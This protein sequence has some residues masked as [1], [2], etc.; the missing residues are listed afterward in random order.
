MCVANY[1]AVIYILLI[2]GLIFTKR[3]SIIYFSQ[4]TCF[5]ILLSPIEVL[6]KYALVL[7]I[8]IRYSYRKLRKYTFSCGEVA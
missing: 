8:H 1:M 5:T 2:V 6:R 7:D 3:T 4:V